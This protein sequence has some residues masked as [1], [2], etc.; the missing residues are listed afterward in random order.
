MQ[1][2]E[3][4]LKVIAVPRTQLSQYAPKITST[5]IPPDRIGELIGPGG[6]V[7]RKLM[8]D[9]GTV[10]DVNDD[11]LVFVTGMDDVKVEEAITW[12]EGL[13]RE[14]LAGEEYEGTV[15]RIQPFGAFVNILPGKDGLVH[16]S[17]MST[18]YVGD[19]NEVV[20]EGQKVKVRVNEVDELG[21]INLTMLTP[22]EEAAKKEAGGGRPPSPGGYGEPRRGGGYFRP[23]RGRDDRGRR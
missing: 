14:V 12:I 23:A 17:R 5:Q 16:V 19:P 4:M 22:E 7:I 18:G 2:L 8:A 10:I 15:V 13:F 21:R 6:K 9:T 11:G 1:I 3:P 20:Q